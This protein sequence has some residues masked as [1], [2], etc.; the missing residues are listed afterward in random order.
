[1]PSNLMMSF[2]GVSAPSILIP[3]CGASLVRGDDL[4]ADQFNVL[5]A[6]GNPFAL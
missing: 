4:D 2:Q 6:A 3:P 1:M 5:H